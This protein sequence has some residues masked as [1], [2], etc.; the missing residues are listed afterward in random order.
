MPIRRSIQFKTKPAHELTEHSARVVH[1]WVQSFFRRLYE[2]IFEGCTFEEVMEQV[3]TKGAGEQVERSAVNLREEISKDK[4][5]Y[6]QF[7]RS[8]RLCLTDDALHEF[9]YGAHELQTADI[10][11]PHCQALAKALLDVLATRLW[12]GVGEKEIFE[13]LPEARFLGLFS[14]KSHELRGPG[15]DYPKEEYS[16]VLSE[17]SKKIKEEGLSD[18]SA[19]MELSRKESVR[20]YPFT[21]AQLLDACD[22]NALAHFAKKQDW[23]VSRLEYVRGVL[24]DLAK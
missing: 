3:L 14:E 13:A 8:L 7:C 24:L 18:Y 12:V 15:P 11:A 4:R 9:T 5:C 17:L 21:G 23:A 10:S 22:K 16:V 6:R 1:A 19:L 2:R 20:I